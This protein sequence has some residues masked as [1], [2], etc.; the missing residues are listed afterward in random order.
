MIG[1][2]PLSVNDLY[3]ELSNEDRLNILHRLQEAPEKLT[4]LSKAVGVTH[5][6]CMRHLNRLVDT[7]LVAK[8][9][10]G[11]YELTH[12]GRAVLR[13]H[14]GFAF[15]SRHR[16][17][18]TS[19]T[20][21]RLPDEFVSRIG[22]LSSGKPTANVMEAISE[23]ES[24]VKESEERLWVIIDKRTRSVRPLVARAVERGVAIRSISPVSYVHSLDVKRDIVEEDEKV[25]VEA[26]AD[27]RAV[28]A[29]ADAFDVYLYLTEKSAF[30]SFPLS[31]G[32]F[33]YT[34]FASSDPAA[35][36]YCTELFEHIWKEAN[37]IPGAEIVERHLEY[38][39]RH[40]E[41]ARF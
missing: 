10:G 21:E 34:G 27:G 22:E 24:I 31:D 19:H 16:D 2:A 37:I 7:G 33:D 18:F 28:V 30:I 39:R 15:I 1:A 20:V 40:D 23:L 6:Q 17:Y 9:G 5:Q 26:E 41:D 38:M 29:D 8:N 4:A 14:R 13:L 36:R 12:Y 11:C 25:V 35:V 32:S 3:F